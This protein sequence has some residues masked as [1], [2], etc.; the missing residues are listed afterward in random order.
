MPIGT[1]QAYTNEV[2]GD[3]EKKVAKIV[4]PDKDVVSSII[5]N[6]SVGVTDP[7]DED[8]GTYY[9]K[10]KITVAFVEFGK[11]NGKDTKAIMTQDT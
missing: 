8:L 9:N 4:E 6:V 11:R 5:S 3:L 1:D 7:T 10:G 2:V